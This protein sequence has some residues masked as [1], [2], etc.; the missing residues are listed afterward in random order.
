MRLQATQAH[1]TKRF[2][3]TTKRNK[4]HPKLRPVDNP[5]KVDA[6][7]EGLEKHG[8]RPEWLQLDWCS[9]A[10]GQKVGQDDA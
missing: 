10:E 2:K 5:T 4:A 7:W 6:L 9:A 1:Q 8:V 3:T